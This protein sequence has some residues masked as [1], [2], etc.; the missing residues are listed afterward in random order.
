MNENPP[1]GAEQLLLVLHG[2]STALYENHREPIDL[3]Q[4][5]VLPTG[6]THDLCI[7]L[8]IG[9]LNNFLHDSFQ[10]RSGIRMQSANISSVIIGDSKTARHQTR[11]SP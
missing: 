7:L 1:M 3:V 8:D 6:I 2:D 9:A 4:R 11:C 5:L 10:D